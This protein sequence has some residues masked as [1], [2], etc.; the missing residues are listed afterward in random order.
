MPSQLQFRL[1]TK[2]LVIGTYMEIDR[3]IL[4]RFEKDKA[5]C[6][7]ELICDASAV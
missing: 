7:F 1:V 3:V 5:L 6:R 4:E 2:V